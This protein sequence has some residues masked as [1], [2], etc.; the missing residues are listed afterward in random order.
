MK[1]KNRRPSIPSHRRPFRRSVLY[2]A[3]GLAV[4]AAA[5]VA[6]LGPD[7]VQASQLFLSSLFGLVVSMAGPVEARR[8]DL[9]TLA[10]LFLRDDPAPGGGAA[11]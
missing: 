6:T 9:Q 10:S 8:E 7:P 2:V 4:G 1:R 5:V 3:T 11:R